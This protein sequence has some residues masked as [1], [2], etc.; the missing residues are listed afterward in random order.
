M[1]HARGHSIYLHHFR[2]DERPRL[3]RGLFCRISMLV[4]TEPQGGQMPVGSPL[5][6]D[7]VVEG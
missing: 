4:R 7:L 1:R 5:G 6:L 2:I 3:V